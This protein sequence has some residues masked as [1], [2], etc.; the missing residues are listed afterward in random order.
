MPAG[1]H[2]LDRVRAVSLLAIES[3]RPQRTLRK[4]GRPHLSSPEGAKAA[5]RPQ[6]TEV[7]SP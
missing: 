7:N 3:G 2:V 1:I 5:T 6:P 4:I